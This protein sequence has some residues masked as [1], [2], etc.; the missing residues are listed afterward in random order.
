MVRTTNTETAKKS[1]KRIACGLWF[2]SWQEWYIQ[3]QYFFHKRGESEIHS[4]LSDS[5]GPH[6]LYSLRNSPGQNTGVGSLSLLQGIFPT[7]GLNPGLLHCRWILNQLSHKESPRILEWVAY[8]FS[9]GSSQ[10]RNR[11]RVS[12]IASR[13]FTNWAIREADK[14]L[15]EVLSSWSSPGHLGSSATEVVI[16][17]PELV[18]TDFRLASATG[19]CT[20]WVRVWAL[21]GYIS[22]LSA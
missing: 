3:P 14:S 10:P 15:G 4:V 9:S 11:T 21:S 7:Q 17:L 16:W 8:S 5:L 19:C 18:A 2:L 22:S 6:G 13:F 20:F 1:L 12:C